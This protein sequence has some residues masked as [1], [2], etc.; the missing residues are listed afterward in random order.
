MT[1]RVPTGLPGSLLVFG[2]TLLLTFLLTGYFHRGQSGRVVNLYIWSSYLAPRTLPRFTE[3]TGIDVRFDLYDS[4]EALLAKIKAE[5]THYD[6]IVPSDYMVETMIHL[7]LLARLDL[8]RVGN[9]RHIDPQFTHLPFDPAGEYGVPYFWGTT[10]IGYRKDKV[11]GPVDSWAALFDPRHK[12]RITMLDDM[13]ENIGAAL[14]RLGYS[15]NE[16]DPAR[17][18]RARDLLLE[19]KRLIKEYNSSSF[20]E[21]LVSG[22]AWI[23]HGFSG[24]IAKAAREYPFIGYTIPRE[25]CTRSVD[26]LCIP[27]SAPHPKEA[28]ALIDYLVSPDVAAELCAYTGYSTPGKTARFLLP[29]ELAGSELVF[30]RPE[31]LAACEYIRDVGPAMN[32]YSTI[33]TEVKS[34]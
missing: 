7:G 15:L 26:Y 3:R 11:A 17:L 6:V 31:R 14:K 10:G 33:W 34:R 24:Q 22:E 9:R 23:V 29:P 12:D 13:R 5:N 21:M 20:Q 30:P 32:L 4:N 1:H 19:Q 2:V 28:H 18:A 25:G 8:A 16:R 27:R